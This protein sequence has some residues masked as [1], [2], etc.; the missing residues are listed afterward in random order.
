[1]DDL[2]LCAGLAQRAVNPQRDKLLASDEGALLAALVKD[3]LASVRLGFTL[4]VYEPEVRLDTDDDLGRER[5]AGILARSPTQALPC[6]Q[7]PCAQ[8]CRQGNSL[9]SCMHS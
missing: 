1:M 4:K 5:L 8:R 2:S 7:R 3:F 6:R 9:V